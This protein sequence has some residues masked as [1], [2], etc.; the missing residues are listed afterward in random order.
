MVYVY[1]L[2]NVN[3]N[4]TSLVG[5]KSAYLGELY[6]MGFN[7][8]EGFVITA[9]AFDRITRNLREE[10]DEILSSVNLNDQ[11]DL[12]KKSNVARNIIMKSDIPGDLKEEI[13]SH[14]DSLNSP[15]VAV[16]STVASNLSGLSF[17]GEYETDLFV[18]RDK[19]VESVKNVIS[20][21]YS[22]RA[23]AYRIA[24]GDSSPIAILI[25]RMINSR[26]AGTAFS[27]H[28]ITEEPDYVFI[29]SAWGLGETVTRGMVTPDQFI[30]SKHSRSIVNKKISSKSVKLAYD[31]DNKTH[32]IIDLDQVQMTSPSLEDAEAVKIANTTIAI[33]N[34]YR[35]AVNIEWAVE[36]S[37]LYVLEVRG[38]RRLYPEV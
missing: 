2:R 31:F 8:P 32:D 18:T 6:N 12:E 36:D 5:R 9:K 26:S 4:M 29:E 13:E 25:Q 20:S 17:A 11:V 3:L 10:I 37:K 23:I 14:F 19:L 33:E 34:V 1:P 28:P 15:Y 16:R 27:L 22:P 30:I 38:I 7:V 21:Y 24:T 35:R